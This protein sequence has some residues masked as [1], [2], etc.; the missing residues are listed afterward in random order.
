[1]HPAQQQ[2]FACR[3]SPNAPSRPGPHPPRADAPH[4]TFASLPALK[5]YLHKQ[6]KLSFCDICLEGRKVG[7]GSTLGLLVS[8]TEWQQRSLALCGIE[9]TT[10]GLLEGR[11]VG[12]AIHLACAQ[13]VLSVG[14][15]VAASEAAFQPGGAQ[16]GLRRS[17]CSMQP[18][19]AC[20]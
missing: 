13:C 7:G 14:H 18:C 12:A 17:R 10:E 9:G 20:M 4:K 15:W 6:H 5:T 2:I 8:G 16:G 3:D 19:W 1:M 11:K